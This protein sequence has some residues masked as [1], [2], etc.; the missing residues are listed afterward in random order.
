MIGGS[1]GIQKQPSSR[2]AVR[3]TLGATAA[4]TIRS[5]RRHFHTVVA[6]CV[7]KTSFPDANC[8][9]GKATVSDEADA[10]RA[11]TRGRG[12][13][14]RPH[15]TMWS[16]LLFSCRCGDRRARHEEQ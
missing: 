14:K 4:A 9:S 11:V 16:W 1:D 3:A 7:R 15:Q 8:P 10:Q 13:R 5:E 6:T 12:D 2:N